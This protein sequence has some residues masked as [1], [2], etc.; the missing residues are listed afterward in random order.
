MHTANTEALD[1]YQRRGFKVMFVLLWVVS[2]VVWRLVG[3]T[4]S[5]HC[6]SASTSMT[7][8]SGVRLQLLAVTL[9]QP[10]TRAV[11]C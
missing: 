8:L 6:A 4:G 3:L 5:V 9:P 7:G 1:F 2:G 10:R 11:T